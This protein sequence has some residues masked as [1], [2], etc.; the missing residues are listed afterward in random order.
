MTIYGSRRSG[1]VFRH[2]RGAI[3]RLSHR[4][5][6]KRYKRSREWFGGG[7]SAVHE[8]SNGWAPF[9][10][11]ALATDTGTSLREVAAVGLT[12][13][14]QFRRH[15]DM[16]GAAFNYS[17]PSAGNHHESVFGSFYRLRLT[18][19]I[20]LGP[21]VEVSIHPTYATKPYTTTLLTH[22]MIVRPRSS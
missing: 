11:Y 10:R 20:D 17:E 18:Q 19:S 13:V 7:F 5:V 9:V 4:H 12:H 2:P 3:S 21:D 15:G 16:F 6:A 1:L 14:H 22:V 8:F